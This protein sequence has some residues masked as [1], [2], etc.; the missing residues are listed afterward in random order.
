MVWLG[1][2]LAL[3]I[4]LTL[5][6]LGGGGSILTVPVFVYVLHFDP[7]LAI[8]MS[9]PV[10]GATSL[11]GA[12][13]HWR[14]GNVHMPS[15]LWFGVFAM[16]G[17]YTAATLSTQLRGRVQLFLLGG[18]ML[19]AATLMLR[20]SFMET[21]RTRA[22]SAVRASR[23]TLAV[24]GLG[25]GALTGIIGIGGGFLIVPALVILAGVPMHQAVGTSLLVITLNALAGFAGQ[26][27][28]TE[29][30]VAFVVTFS[31]VAMI[32]ILA[33]TRLARHVEQRLL[34]Q[35]FAVL[36]LI[37]ACWVLWQNHGLL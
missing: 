17:A 24:V 37:L 29:I 34:K 25:V 15:A 1:Y 9:L 14:A 32:G 6:T 30:P 12:I 31:V 28:R 21:G 11:V 3:I 27:Q 33:G 5:G 35:A 26:R 19:A 16:T 20:N 36:L 8:A 23:A 13:G 7:K 2:L 22:V 4:G 18:V 10:V